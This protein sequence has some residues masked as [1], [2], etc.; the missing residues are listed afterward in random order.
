MTR[1]Y[2]SQY[3]ILEAIRDR[4]RSQ[5]TDFSTATTC[6]ISDTPNPVRVPSADAF[7]VVSVGD[8]QF[9]DSHFAGGGQYTCTEDAL[10]QVT[11]YLQHTSD[12]TDRL[13]QGLLSSDYGIIRVYKQAILKALLVSW[14]PTDGSG[15]E[16]LRSQLSPVSATTPTVVEASGGMDFITFTLTF[17]TEFDWDLS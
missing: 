11:V 10:V 14:E 16:L 8:G 17:R 5:V 13:Q 15:N 7:C 2:A 12:E 3:E 9:N 6:F 1:E 4:L